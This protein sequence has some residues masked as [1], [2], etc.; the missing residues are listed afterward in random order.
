MR[1][2]GHPVDTCWDGELE[3]EMRRGRKIKSRAAYGKSLRIAVN[4]GRKGGAK[5]ASYCEWEVLKSARVGKQ[6][7]GVSWSPLV[8][9]QDNTI[10]GS[11]IA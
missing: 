9:T 7:R 6:E 10:G 11:L 2:G 1:C 8:I 5:E 4:A 3:S